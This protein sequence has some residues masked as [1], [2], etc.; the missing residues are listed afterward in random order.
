MA[1]EHLQNAAETCE[2]GLKDFTK[3]Q[4]NKLNITSKYGIKTWR[5]QVIS[6]VIMASSTQK[7]GLFTPGL[8]LGFVSARAIQ[9]FKKYCTHCIPQWLGWW[10]VSAVT[11][12]VCLVYCIYELIRSPAVGIV[13]R[14]KKKKRFEINNHRKKGGGESTIVLLL[15][16]TLWLYR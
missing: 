1:R 14:K 15:P 6:L 10:H 3:K 2:I 11:K 12:G 4:H 7:P 9:A 8:L 16:Y 5:Y 13:T